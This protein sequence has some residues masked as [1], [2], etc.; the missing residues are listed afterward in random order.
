[1][2]SPDKLYPQSAQWW[3]GALVM[4][5]WS[6]LAGTVGVLLTRKRDIS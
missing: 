3:V 4:I 1:M 6:L 2:I 5:G